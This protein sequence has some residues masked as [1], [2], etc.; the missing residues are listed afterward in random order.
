M[1]PPSMM[2]TEIQPLAEAQE[3]GVRSLAKQFFATKPAAPRESVA[4][5]DVPAASKSTAD[6][7][8]AFLAGATANSA[9][10]AHRPPISAQKPLPR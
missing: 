9:A 4:S 8:S 3:S 5:I 7:R 6:L 10:S 2:K 1:P